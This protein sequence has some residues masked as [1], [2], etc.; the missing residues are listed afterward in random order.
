MLK[1]IGAW[2]NAKGA[3][4]I[5][6]FEVIFPQI[7]GFVDMAIGIDHALIRGAS[8]LRH[9]N[10]LLLC[11]TVQKEFLT[12]EFHIREFHCQGEAK[13]SL[14]ASRFPHNSSSHQ[15]FKDRLK[16]P[17]RREG[18]DLLNLVGQ[19]GVCNQLRK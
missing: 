15:V 7:R 6:W 4:A 9:H 14:K 17:T 1:P 5:M 8:R 12:I 2:T 18:K 3:V 13:T 16:V 19:E 11:S 10:C